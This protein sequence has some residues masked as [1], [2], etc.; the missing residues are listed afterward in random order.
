LDIRKEFF[1]NQC[2]EA[3]AQVALRGGGCSV[4]GSTHGQAALGSV[5]PDLA[6]GVPVYFRGVGAG[7]LKDSLPVEVILCQVIS[8]CLDLTHL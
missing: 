2:D 5:Q 7:D 1:Y 4:P 8:F 6:L 3:L